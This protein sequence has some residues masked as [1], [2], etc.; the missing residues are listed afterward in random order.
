[1]HLYS[2]CSCS[3]CNKMVYKNEPSISANKSS[4]SSELSA[5]T[6]QVHFLS[7]LSLLQMEPLWMASLLRSMLKALCSLPLGI[8]PSSVCCG[9]VHGSQLYKNIYSSQ[10]WQTHYSWGIQICS[11]N[12]GALAK[13]FS[14]TGS[15]HHLKGR[16]LKL[17]QK[18][19]HSRFSISSILNIPVF[20]VMSPTPHPLLQPGFN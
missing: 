17:P 4:I 13:T 5:H 10:L 1:M 2:V 7:V 8:Q 6:N 18:T 14:I 9:A 19:T 12:R 20:T 11:V 16:W 15:H 3:Y